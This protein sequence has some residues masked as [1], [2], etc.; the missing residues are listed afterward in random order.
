M[1]RI[2]ALL[3]LLLASTATA[4]SGQFHGRTPIGPDFETLT[5]RNSDGDDL[6]IHMRVDEADGVYVLCIATSGRENEDNEE[7]MDYQLI[8][9]NGQVIMRGTGWAPHYRN[10]NGRQAV[11][12]KTGARIVANPQFTTE[13]SQYNF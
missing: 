9:L 5:V 1:R 6:H 13:W 7:L 2:I 12:Q 4:Q 11:C 8:L 3:P 10:P